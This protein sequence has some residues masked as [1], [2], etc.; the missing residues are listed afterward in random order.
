M[1]L[2][3]ARVSVV[4]CVRQRELGVEIRAGAGLVEGRGGRGAG[5]GGGRG[6]G[7]GARGVAGPATQYNMIC[8]HG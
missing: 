6:R 8:R 2:V 1:Y 5:P 4:G 7:Q 3:V